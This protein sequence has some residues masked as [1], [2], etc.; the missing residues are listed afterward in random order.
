MRYCFLSHCARG[1]QTAGPRLVFSRRNWMPDGVGNFAHRAAQRVDFANQMAL[2]DAADGGIARHLRDQ[3][4]VH[5]DHRGAQAHASACTRGLA[6]G[7][8]GAHDNDVISR[9]LHG[10]HFQCGIL[11]FDLPQ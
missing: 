8:A 3:V 4:Q 9:R 2:R 10:F 7:V 1:D 5:R 6:T 11:A